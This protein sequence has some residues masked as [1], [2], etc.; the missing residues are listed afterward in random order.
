[1]WLRLYGLAFQ[2]SM[3]RGLES[4]ATNSIGRIIFQSSLIETS[5]NLRQPASQLHGAE[6]GVPNPFQ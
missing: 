2:N 3:G 4:G 1:M 6:P 5:I